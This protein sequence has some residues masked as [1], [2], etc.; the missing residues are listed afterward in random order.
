MPLLISTTIC[1]ILSAVFNGL[2]GGSSFDKALVSLPARKKMGVKI[3]ATYSRTNDLGR[4]LIVYPAL[5]I[6]TPAI[7]IVAMILVLLDT[8]STTVLITMAII[9]SG[10]SLAHIWTTSHAAPVM[11]GLRK[12]RDDD[13]SQLTD[14]FDRFAKWHGFRAILQVLTMVASI[15]AIVSVSF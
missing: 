12:L 10:L 14:I 1:L 5:G 4:G 2:L 7:T 6:G 9:A 15:L 13:E 11:L 8:G 3:F